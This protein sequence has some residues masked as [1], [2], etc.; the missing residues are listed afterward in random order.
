[1]VSCITFGLRRFLWAVKLVQQIEAFAAKP[2]DFANPQKPHGGHTHAIVKCK[3]LLLQRQF[4]F[5]K[6]MYFNFRWFP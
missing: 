5:T 4:C 3:K 6:S 1:M 2:N